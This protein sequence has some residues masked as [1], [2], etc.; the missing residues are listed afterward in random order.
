MTRSGLR[1]AKEKCFKTLSEY[2]ELRTVQRS[3][4]VE[5]RSKCW[6]RKPEKPV[7]RR[8]CTQCHLKRRQSSFSVT[9]AKNGDCPPIR[10]LSPNSATN[11]SASPV[12]TGLK[13]KYG[14]FGA[15]KPRPVE[16]SK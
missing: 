1:Q 8:C 10:R 16:D 7:C 14:M 5:D 12:W 4:V 11:M 6:R 15:I 13:A 3:R 9:V 2:C